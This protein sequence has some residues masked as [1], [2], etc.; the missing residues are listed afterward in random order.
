MSLT[1][2]DGSGISREIFATE[3]AANIFSNIVTSKDFYLAVSMGMVPGFATND[4]F[5]ATDGNLPS[6]TANIDIW[7]QNKEYVFSDVSDIDTASSSSSADTNILCEVKGI[8]DFT[9][10]TG[11]DTGYFQLNGQN[12]VL[13]YDNNALT[14]TPISFQRVDRVSNISNRGNPVNGVAYVYVD[15]TIVGGVPV[16]ADN[17]RASINNGNNQTLMAVYTTRPKFVSFL[18]R[19][20]L[21]LAWEGGGFSGVE[22]QNFQYRSGRKDKEFRVKKKISLM[23]AGTSVYQDE[24]TFPDIIP[25]LTDIVIRSTNRTAAMGAEAAFDIL[26]VDENLFT[27]AFLQEIGQPGV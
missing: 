12:K 20:E 22:Y 10:S 18:V 16:N 17:I 13:I 27:A 6:G 14:G 8:R 9:T 26:L 11:E 15:G 5:G 7:E 3:D 25:A 19:G 2:L 4:K 1:I 24:R 21:S 23:T